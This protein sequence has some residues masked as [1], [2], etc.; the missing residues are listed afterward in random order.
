MKTHS[1]NTG[2]IVN[3][4][5][6]YILESGLMKVISTTGALL[7]EKYIGFDIN[8]SGMMQDEDEIASIIS[9]P[10]PD[11]MHIVILTKNG[12]IIKY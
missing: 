1:F 5:I 2:H 12:K 9:S 4:G 11:D 10:I 3:A 7:L 8:P 6:L